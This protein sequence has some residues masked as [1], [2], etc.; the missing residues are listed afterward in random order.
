MHEETQMHGLKAKGLKKGSVSNWAAV[1]IGL[2]ATAPA[3]SLAGALGY[4]AAGSGYQLPIVFILSVIPMFFVALSYKHLTTAAPDAGT[5]F[6]WGTKAIG[7]RIGWFGGWALLLGSVL[8]GVAATQITVISV[9]VIFG[10]DETPPWFHIVVAVLFIFSTTYLTALG[11][12]E[13]SRTTMILT[14]AQYSILI[15][16]AGILYMR[17]FQGE[18]VSTAE[19]FSWEWFNPLAIPSFDVFLKGF[20]IALFIFWGF[21]ASLAM[22][23]E[24]EGDSE[25][26]GRSGIIAMSITI[27]TYVVFSIAAL[28]YAGIDVNHESSLTHSRNI[29]SSI[30][31]LATEIIGAQGAMV[32]A[33]IIC[34]SAFSATMS[35]I[36]PSARIALAMAT[37]RALPS[38]FAQVNS[39]TRTPKFT[40][41][42]IGLMT[43]VIYTTLSLLSESIVEDTILS[44]S[45]A[46]CTFYT[47]A[48]LSCA[49]YFHRTAFNHWRTALSQV[50]FPAFAAIVLI[51]VAIL[52]AWNMMDPDY[53]SSGSIAGVGAVFMIGVVS[54]LFGVVLMALWNLR[55]PSF[56]RGETLPLERAHMVMDTLDKIRANK[57]GE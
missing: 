8:A 36:M 31:T 30:T 13:S 48:A 42:T 28:A 7:P 51:A 55:A 15:L 32:A 56:F 43:L 57:A 5:I 3:Y 47:V 18:A 27:F 2:A 9:A 44:V 26:A 29:D 24:T 12:R 39:V 23:E 4:G 38:P 53:G 50:V 46:V 1:T 25:Q 49:L 35:T 33:V 10:M 14:I 21:D 40:T 37:Y 52:Q 34:V 19:P 45:I 22:S 16:L 6:T 17:V 20:M 54:L 41:W 11:A